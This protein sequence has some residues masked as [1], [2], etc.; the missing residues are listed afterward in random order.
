MVFA[1]YV[2][3]WK[4]NYQIELGLS[5]EPELWYVCPATRQGRPVKR[6]GK[7][8]LQIDLSVSVRSSTLRPTPPIAVIGPLSKLD[9]L[10]MVFLFH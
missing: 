7:G 6:G 5:G 3:N 2:N 9:K 4:S 10:W 1:K 8:S